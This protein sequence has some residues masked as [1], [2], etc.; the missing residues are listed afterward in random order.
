[1]APE[2]RGG[3]IRSKEA[4]IEGEV[5]LPGVGTALMLAFAGVKSLSSS[6]VVAWGRM[7]SINEVINFSSSDLGKVARG[8]TFTKNKKRVETNHLSLQVPV[9]GLSNP[10]CLFV[11]LLNNDDR[12]REWIG[13]ILDKDWHRR[14]P[15]S[16]EASRAGEE[17]VDPAQGGLAKAKQ[18]Q[19][20]Q[21]VFLVD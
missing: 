17:V 8:S 6:S 20:G 10:F 21:T 14:S 12:F 4:Q 16:S 9:Y 1:M 15:S 3:V 18:A 13:G 11:Y 5:V 2:V 19:N 7:A